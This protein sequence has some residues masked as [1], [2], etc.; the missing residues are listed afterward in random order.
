MCKWTCAAQ[1]HVAQGSTIIVIRS[2]LSSWIS[3]A[4]GKKPR[5]PMRNKMTQ[6]HVGMCVYVCACVCV[7][8]YVCGDE[9]VYACH[10]GACMC[11]VWMSVWVLGARQGSITV[12]RTLG[13]FSYSKILRGVLHLLHLIPTTFCVYYPYFQQV[14]Q[15]Y[16]WTFHPRIL[17]TSSRFLCQYPMQLSMPIWKARYGCNA[18]P[19]Y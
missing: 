19:A 1:T 2:L 14:L 7:C 8:E 12:V 6:V 4:L 11:I 18:S 5:M 13:S 10:M 16:F 15:I 3:K 9:H 17:S